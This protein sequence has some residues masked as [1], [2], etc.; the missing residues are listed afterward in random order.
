MAEPKPCSPRQLR[1]GEI[2]CVD[3]NNPSVYRF[4]ENTA[5]LS[6]PGKHRREISAKVK[7]REK[8]RPIRN[9]DDS[10]QK[11]VHDYN[12]SPNGKYATHFGFQS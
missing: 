7:D 4:A 11:G 10:T 3:D 12:I 6:L 8:P 2:K 1:I 5:I 9:G